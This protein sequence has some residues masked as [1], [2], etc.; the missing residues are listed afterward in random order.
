LPELDASVYG[1]CQAALL[2]LE[3]HVPGS[4]VAAGS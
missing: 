2:N 4:G 3:G 1:E